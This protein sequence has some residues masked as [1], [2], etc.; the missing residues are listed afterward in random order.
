MSDQEK[1]DHLLSSTDPD[2]A[3]LR[4]S[5]TVQRNY[6]LIDRTLLQGSVLLLSLTMIAD[7]I[8]IDWFSLMKLKV[9][10]VH[11]VGFS[12]ISVIPTQ[13]RQSFYLRYGDVGEIS[14]A[15]VP[16][17][18]QLIHV[19]DSPHYVKLPL[20][21][22]GI[23]D[24][25]DDKTFSVLVGS[26]FIDAILCIVCTLRDMSSL[27][28]LTLKGIFE[29]VYIITQKYDFEDS[30]FTHLQHLLRRAIL[31]IVETLPQDDISYEIRLL[32]LTIAQASIKRCHTV[33][34]ST[35]WCVP[36]FPFFFRNA[37]SPQRNP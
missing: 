15:S 20:S 36:F 28:V 14:D 9:Y 29:S 31:R 1:P 37:C 7:G 2:M 17:L 22:L 10:F 13:S 33:L 4:A 3:R 23:V 8:E 21:A 27:P 5:S 32:C 18:E 34:G 25:H 16:C 26:I 19:V 11:F 30:L 24:D 12:N 6:F 35:I